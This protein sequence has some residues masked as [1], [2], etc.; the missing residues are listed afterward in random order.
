MEPTEN[1]EVEAF[2]IVGNWAFQS[3]YMKGKH[4]Q[5]TDADLKFETGKED[6][7]LGRIGSRLDKTREE[8]IAVIDRMHAAMM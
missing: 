4:P 5:L 2:K 8:V 6:E 3:K 1:K 7:L